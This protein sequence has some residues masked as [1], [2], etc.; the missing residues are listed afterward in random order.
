[1]FSCKICFW[2]LIYFS[3]SAVSSELFALILII[4][5]ATREPVN[6]W[7]AFFT[8]PNPPSPIVYSVFLK[9][10]LKS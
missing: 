6:L 10:I 4:F 7:T 2:I 5:I 9:Y 1:M 8:L 3:R